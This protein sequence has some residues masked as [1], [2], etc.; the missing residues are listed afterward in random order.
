MRCVLT[1]GIMPAAALLLLS[2]CATARLHS[3]AELNVAARDC[4]LA[5]GELVQEVDKEAR[6]LLFLF[7]I[8]PS[9]EQRI[10]VARWA[11]KRHMRPVIIEA[12]NE[13]QA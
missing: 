13:P 6:K 11:R 4:G 8:A 7:R 3:Q 2:G 12:I 9:P 5:L 10:C 1:T